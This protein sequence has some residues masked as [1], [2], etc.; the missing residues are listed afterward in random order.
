MVAPWSM[1]RQMEAVGLYRA[2]KT[3]VEIAALMSAGTPVIQK[4]LRRHGV[5]SRK[6]TTRPWAQE[7]VQRLIVEYESGKTVAQVSRENGLRTATVLRYLRE[8]G[9][10]IRYFWSESDL[11]R[12]VQ[13]YEA[14]ATVMQCAREFDRDHHSVLFQLRKQGAKMR[15]Q[16][17]VS[18]KDH[19]MWNGGRCRN[20]GYVYIKSPGHPHAEIHGYVLEHRLVM[21]KHVGRY[22]L[23][24]EVVHHKNKKKDDNRIENLE[25]FASN[26][27]HLAH[28]LKGQCPKWSEE[29]KKRIREAHE[30]WC[31]RQRSRPR[32]RPGGPR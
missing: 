13:M 4:Y 19:H 6:A 18:G 7:K 15:R 8:A 12:L 11:T 29:G 22:L 17:F 2:G 14:G 32:P 24:G 27:E 20:G 9:V 10:E 25:L 26:G 23:P 21:E 16:H 5:E 3:L 28:E 30:Q 31:Q 1:D